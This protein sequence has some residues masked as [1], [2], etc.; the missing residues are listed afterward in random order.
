M[1]AWI[2]VISI[3]RYQDW[4]YFDVWIFAHWVDKGVI[5]SWLMMTYPRLDHMW[6]MRVAEKIYQAWYGHRIDFNGCT[7]FLRDWKLIR[8]T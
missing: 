3:W 5:I 4:N 6:L 2:Y 8:T 7:Y 1:W